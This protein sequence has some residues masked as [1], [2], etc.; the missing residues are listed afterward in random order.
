MSAA[1]PKRILFY[2]QHLLGTGHLQRSVIIT[3]ELIR[4][5]F[6]VALISGGRDVPTIDTGSV[7]LIQLPPMH[8]LNGDFDTLVDEHDQPVDE[9][10]WSLRRAQLLSHLTE[11]S[12]DAV[13]TETFPFGRRGMRHELVPFI[14][15]ARTQGCVVVCSVRDI[16]QAKRKPERFQ[17]ALEWVNE[18]YNLVLIHGDPEFCE[19]KTTFPLTDRIK[20]PL[21]YTGFVTHRTQALIDDSHLEPLNDLD[22]IVSAGGGAM[23]ARI[24]QAVVAAAKLPEMKDRHFL[25]LVGRNY[26]EENKNK[27]Q[28]DA[29]SNVLVRW[30]RPDFRLLL[31]RARVSISQSGYNTMLD[32]I[33]SRIPSVLVPYEDGGETEQRMRAECLLKH[34]PVSILPEQ[35]VNAQQM[36]A[37]IVNVAET[38]RSELDHQFAKKGTTDVRPPAGTVSGSTLALN[39]AQES[40][41]V[42]AAHLQSS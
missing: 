22:I 41:R 31:Q 12:P 15:Q 21:T 16:L 37:A 2:V 42:I 40:A 1:S 8:A 23:G 34:Q 28:A 20:P 17:E 5:G 39:G 33:E 6:E 4:A 13:V 24:Y 10:F 11:F 30:A 32:L 19:F 18:Y 3:R 29:G 27:L 7:R 14:Q 25:I 38:I 26:G 9:K 35:G 36:A